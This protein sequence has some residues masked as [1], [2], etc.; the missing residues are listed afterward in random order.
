MPF[1][2]LEREQQKSGYFGEKF[3]KKKVTRFL[4]VQKTKDRIRKNIKL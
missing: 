2:C 1:T 3:A 4:K